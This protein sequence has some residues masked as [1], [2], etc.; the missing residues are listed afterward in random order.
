MSLSAREQHALD[1]IGDELSGTDPKL[2]SMLTAF[3]RLT[4]G[5][6][7]PTRESI[8]PGWAW[9]TGR[10]RDPHR[11]GGA[12]PSRPSHPRAATLA[13]PAAHRAGALAADRGRAD[14]GSAG[15]HR[16][17]GDAGAG[18]YPAGTGVA[19]RPS[20]GPRQAGGAVPSRPSRPRATTLA[21]PPAHR[22]G[23]LAA[24]R[25]RADRGSAGH[26]RGRPGETVPRPGRR[27]PR[28]G[29]HVQGAA[30]RQRPRRP[31]ARPAGRAQ[32]MALVSASSDRDRADHGEPPAAPF[33]W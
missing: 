3:T 26:H 25:G 21:G 10:R 33:P 29:A 20:T 23:A 6:E 1:C 16:G 14:R 18:E 7:M 9:R 32:L 11:A 28:A 12:V 8:R 17:R 4:A 13:G 31:P 27:L 15:H 30:V 2:A 5:E 24:D 22:A 19:H